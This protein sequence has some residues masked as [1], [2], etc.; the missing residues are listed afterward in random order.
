MYMY[1]REHVANEKKNVQFISHKCSYVNIF[2]L[3]AE[4]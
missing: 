2:E 1:D 3:E 4:N